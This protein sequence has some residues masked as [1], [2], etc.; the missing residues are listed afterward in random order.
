M[1]LSRALL[2]RCPWQAFGLTED[3]QYYLTLVQN[4]EKVIYMPEAVVK[5]EMPLTFAQMRTQDIRWEADQ[6]GPSTWKAAWQLLKVGTRNRDFRRLE[7]IG[8]LLTP[9]L[10]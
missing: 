4:G 7:A 6:G 5:A 10:S 1:C 2:Q 8:E 3:Y 9:P